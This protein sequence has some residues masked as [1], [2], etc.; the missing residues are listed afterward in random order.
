PSTAPSTRT[1]SRDNKNASPSVLAALTPLGVSDD[2]P[3]PPPPTPVMGSSRRSSHNGSGGGDGAGGEGVTDAN[4]LHFDRSIEQVAEVA[5]TMTV[6]GAVV[7]S[8]GP[9][10]AAAGA[11]GGVEPSASGRSSVEVGGVAG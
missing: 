2:L 3:P 6:L 11:T 10:A 5:T 9:E 7:A 1:I 4:P 8:A